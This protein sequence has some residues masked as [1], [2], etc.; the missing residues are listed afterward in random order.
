MIKDYY[1]QIIGIA[2]NVSELTEEQVRSSRDAESCVTRR[3][4]IQSLLRIATEKKVAELMGITRQAVNH[5]KNCHCKKTNTI[6][7]KEL[8]KQ[9][10]KK[11]Q[12]IS[13]E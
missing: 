12:E 1:K 4:L 13:N 7:E 2:L 6:L 8:I 3:V 11:L 10:E 9:I 5:C